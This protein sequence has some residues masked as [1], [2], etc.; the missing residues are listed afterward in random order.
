MSYLK[1]QNSAVWMAVLCVCILLL[2]A[3]PKSSSPQNPDVADTMRIISMA[4]NL[5]EILFALGLDEQIVAVA[6]ESDYPPQALQ[7]RRIGSFWQPDIEAVLACRP[8]L[9]I[10]ESFEQQNVLASRLKGIGCRTVVVDV[11]SIS[12]LH[13]A[14]YAIGQAVDRSAQAEQLIHR[15][16][17]K[18]DQVA[19]RHQNAADKPKV[20]W[21]IQRQP[22]RAAG[23]NSFPNELIEIAGGINVVTETVYRYPPIS[24]EF[25]LGTMPDVIIEPTEETVDPTAQLQAARAFYAKYPVPAVQHGRIYVIDADKI[26]RLGPRLD[27]GMDLV[28]QCLWPG[29][30]L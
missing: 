28:D 15:L 17:R 13:T 16:K 8:T 20:L 12:E 6:D 23:R 21:V 2:A 29:A 19:A 4:P 26:S 25:L 22:L 27:E 3:C 30:G 14:I 7:K 24:A 9:V 5:T 18:Q 11:W 1:L 10:T